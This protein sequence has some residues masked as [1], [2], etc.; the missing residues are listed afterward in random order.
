MPKVDLY[1]L[2]DVGVFAYLESSLTWTNPADSGIRCLTFI[3]L[4]P[5]FGGV[6]ALEI[7]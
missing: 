2:F 1:F 7:F 6:I 4:H 5:A 3:F